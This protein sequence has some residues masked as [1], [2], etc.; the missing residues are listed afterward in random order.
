MILVW[1]PVYN[2]VRFV[3]QAI[4]SILAQTH[5]D[6]LLVV[7]DN[8]SNDGSSE[9]IDRAVSGDIR[10]TKV[11]PPKHMA[12]IDHVQ[13]LWDQVLPTFSNIKYTIFIGGHDIW[14]PN[15]LECLLARA[16]REPNASI[17]FPDTLQMDLDGNVTG[18]FVHQIQIVIQE[19]PYVPHFVLLGLT[20]NDVWGGLWEESRRR[21]VQ[22][23]YSC[24]GADNL[25]VAEAGLHGLILH[26]PLTTLYLRLAP[27]HKEGWSG[28]LKKHISPEIRRSGYKDFLNQLDWVC[29]IADIASE[30]HHFCGQEVVRAMYK[31]SLLSAYICRYVYHLNSENGLDVYYSFF[32]NPE[33]REYLQHQDICMNVIKRLIENNSASK[34]KG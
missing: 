6:F 13:Y 24:C 5:G 32:E 26:E 15:L 34:E 22:L 23:R 29:T 7:S 21:K 11:S 8:H 20:V 9:I 17:V 31:T 14:A 16:L 4:D 3:K 25:M 2:E 12:S 27:N 1:M 19:K 28:Y 30:G 18:K 10:I 33:V